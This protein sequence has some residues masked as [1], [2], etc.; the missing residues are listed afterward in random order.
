MQDHRGVTPVVSVV[1]PSYNSAKYVRQCLG[2]IRAQSTELPFEIILVD[3]SDDG[4]DQIVANEFREVRLLHFPKR[5][6]VGAGRNIG[7]ERATGEVVLFLDTDCIAPPTWIDQMYTAI[8]SFGADGVGG[9]VENG[10]PWSITGSAGFYL[11]FFRFLVSHDKPYATLFLMGGNSGFRRDEFRS[12][13]YRETSVGDDIMFTWQLVKKGKHLLFL[14]SATVKHMNKTGWMKVLRYQYKLGVGACGYRY[15]TSPHL[16]YHLERLPVL[17]FLI[18]VAVMVWIGCTVLR[19]CGILE[20]L[21][22]LALLP[23]LYIANNVWAIGFYRELKNQ[24]SNRKTTREDVVEG[25]V[26]KPDGL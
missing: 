4:T 6:S 18:P 14:P 17:T 2:A 13:R 11:E 23:L 20:F 7:V 1:I 9:S 12:A 5:L 25:E 10:T 22:L 15:N 21:K 24:R 19:R 8:K 3:S 26:L 16:M